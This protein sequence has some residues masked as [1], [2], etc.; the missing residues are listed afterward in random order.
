[1]RKLF[2]RLEFPDQLKATFSLVLICSIFFC[3]TNSSTQPTNSR[4]NRQLEELCNHRWIELQKAIDS[5]LS[6]SAIIYSL[7]LS[8]I[9]VFGIWNEKWRK[10]RMQTSQEKNIQERESKSDRDHAIVCNDSTFSVFVCLWKCCEAHSSNVQK[11]QS[12]LQ[13]IETSAR[14]LFWN[15]FRVINLSIMD[16]A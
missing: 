2:F 11:S 6:A 1:M 4:V 15:T 8:E 16:W 10:W 12:C 3:K 5:A 9:V 14:E 13:N 7:F